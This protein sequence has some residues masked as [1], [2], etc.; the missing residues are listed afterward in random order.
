MPTS[1]ITAVIT[2][3]A[4]LDRSD[5]TAHWRLADAIL[6][7]EPALPE[8]RPVGYSPLEGGV[9]TSDRL[10][11]L[12]TALRDAG[13]T[14]VK[15]DPYSP[16]HLDKLRE[17]AMAWPPAE[18]HVEAAHRTHIEASN[19]FKRTVLAK[20]CA[21]SRG[22]VVRRPANVDADAWNR[23]VERVRT[24]T[25]GHAVVAN[26]LR[27]AVNSPTNN[28]GP[29]R[30]PRAEDASAAVREHGVTDVVEAM[31]P[32]ERSDMLS[33][34]Q[35]RATDQRF[36]DSVTEANGQIDAIRAIGNL[37][38]AKANIRQAVRDHQA[39]IA[40]GAAPD[41]HRA[42]F[43]EMCDEL[44]SISSVA[45]D[46]ARGVSDDALFALLDQEVGS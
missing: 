39:A 46:I 34:L 35:T 41:H 12:A 40:S 2:A 20:L 14:T 22:E 7:H 32:D 21:V 11:E 24:R 13:V 37:A 16:G 4:T 31:T 10:T 29:T 25:S 6:A 38:K 1:T 26:D 5:T 19:D 3:A 15:G 17:S 44:V 42:T 27:I 18:R 43:A 8:G 23:A 45:G 30:T 36:D 33:E 28:T 9:T